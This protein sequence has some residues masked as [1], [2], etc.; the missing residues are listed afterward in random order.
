MSA[1]G[2]SSSTPTTEVEV[3]TEG[4]EVLGSSDG[5]LGSERHL[6]LYLCVDG[7][8]VLV[9]VLQLKVFR[10]MNGEKIP[11]IFKDSQRYEGQV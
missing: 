4:S 8:E 9:A 11:I 7:V 3:L 10:S 5:I 1:V 6:H 2:C